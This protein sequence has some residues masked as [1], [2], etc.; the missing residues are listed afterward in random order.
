MLGCA[1]L[2]RTDVSDEFSASIIR[3][4][5]IGK[6]GT[7]LAVTINRRK[8]RAHFSLCIAIIIII[9]IIIHFNYLLFMCR[10]N[11]YKANYRHCTVQIHNYIRDRFI[12]E[13]RIN[14]RSI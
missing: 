10:T 9:I 6:L 7:M 2:I 8:Q 12:I 1:A 3:V 5:R 13:S 14:C 4:T 11:S